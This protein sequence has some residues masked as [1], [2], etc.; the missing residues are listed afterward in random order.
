[1]T[2]TK[3]QVLNYNPYMA[4]NKKNRSKTYQLLSNANHAKIHIL[5]NRKQV[6]Q[7]ISEIKKEYGR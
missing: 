3:K 6:N 4:K 7:F 2:E 5:K 1:M